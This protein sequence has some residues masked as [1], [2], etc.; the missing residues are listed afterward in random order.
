[1]GSNPQG[2]WAMRKQS[3]ELL[4]TEARCTKVDSLPEPC[5]EGGRDQEGERL[6]E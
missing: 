3:L 6:Q 2:F 4:V 1:M 5:E